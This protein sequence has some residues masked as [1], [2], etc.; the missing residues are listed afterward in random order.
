MATSPTNPY[1]SYDVVAIQNIDDEDFTFEYD[2]SR[3]NFAHVIPAGQVR[4]FP[5]FLAEHALKHLIDKILN[6]QNVSTAHL[7]RRQELAT[8]IVINEES[9]AP[10]PAKP[11]A[12]K[13]RE[14]V[15][16]LNKPS[17]LDVILNK[18]R[19][20]A[21]AKPKAEEQ[22]IETP[23]VEEEKFEGLEDT[24]KEAPTEELPIRPTP[25]R[26]EIIAYARKQGMTIDADAEKKFTSWKIERMLKELGDPR[27]EI[28]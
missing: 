6:K 25:T 11:E 8:Q 22:V 16:N 26:K 5:R 10:A 15:E 20:E 27:E 17:E 13:L 24:T 12:E 18:R 1:Q 4:R 21:E 28:I 23:K 14:E 19:A 9:F 3:G 2:R 7:S